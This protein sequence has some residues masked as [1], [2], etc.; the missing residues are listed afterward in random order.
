[1]GNFANDVAAGAAEP[2]TT[3]PGAAA[4][5]PFSG[6]FGTLRARFR[7]TSV[8]ADARSETN[9]GLD[10]EKGKPKP[11]TEMDDVKPVNYLRLYASVPSHHLDCFFMA[12]R[13]HEANCW[14]LYALL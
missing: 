5:K 10:A 4:A 8:K 9:M 1:M 11:K 3:L 6:F 7:P 14:C 13:Q 2:A 12:T